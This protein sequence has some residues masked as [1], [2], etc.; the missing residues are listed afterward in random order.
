MP[1]SP[2]SAATKRK[3]S[4]SVRRSVGARSPAGSLSSRSPRRPEI[5][6]AVQQSPLSI[7]HV[8][9]AVASIDEAL[10]F[11]GDKLGLSV[12]DQLDLPER[13]LKVAFIQAANVLIALLEPTATDT[14]VARF[15]D[16]PRP[17]PPP[18]SSAP[19]NLP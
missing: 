14:P 4:T 11:Y 7:H 13:Q 2:S 18:L 5:L 10:H 6:A 3:A 16:R 1:W 15:L 17:P 19:P 12:C 9:I 8:G